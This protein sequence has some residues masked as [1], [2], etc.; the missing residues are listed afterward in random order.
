MPIRLVSAKKSR[1]EI[2]ELQRLG[3]LPR[4]A[5][6]NWPPSAKKPPK[7]PMPPKSSSP[8][9]KANSNRKAAA[10]RNNP[11]PAGLSPALGG[12]AAKTTHGGTE[13]MALGNHPKP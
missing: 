4:L 3:L 6:P 2:V 8:S 11:F 5:P 13:G 10:Q 7:P 12:A 1:R 9:T